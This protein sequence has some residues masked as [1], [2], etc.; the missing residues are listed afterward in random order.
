MARSHG[1]FR[2]VCRSRRTFPAA[3]SVGVSDAPCLS[4]HFRVC[5]PRGRRSPCQRR[6]IACRAPRSSARARTDGRS[7][8]R[9]RATSKQA[10]QGRGGQPATRFESMFWDC[11]LVFLVAGLGFRRRC[12]TLIVTKRT[13]VIL[14]EVIQTAI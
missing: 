7:R 12:H 11:S 8:D 3:T 9:S 4:R 6:H 10:E 5:R 13:A 1:G 2:I 14:L